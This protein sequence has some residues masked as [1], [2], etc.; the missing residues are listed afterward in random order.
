MEDYVVLVDE[1]DRE[2][3]TAEKIA[4]HSD[5][6]KLH[7]AVDVWLIDNKDR[8]LLQQRADS[9]Y[10]AGGLWAMTCSGHPHHGEDAEAAAHRKLNEEM[11]IDCI[12]VPAFKFTYKAYI[13]KGMTEHEYVHSFFGRYSENPK[14]DPAEVKAWKYLP[15]TQVTKSVGTN[16][17]IYAPWFRI[18]F[19]AALDALRGMK[20]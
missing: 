19:P 16:S 1:E 4:A 8:M 6:G 5:G 13:G 10:H 20:W 18:M 2:L 12:L 14:P 7:R 9:K 15:I 3:S 11:G 17:A